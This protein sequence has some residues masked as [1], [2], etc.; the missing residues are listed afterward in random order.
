MET[1]KYQEIKNDIIKRIVNFELTGGDKVPSEAELQKM[2]SVSATTVVKALNELVSEG[3][4]YRVQGKGTFVT[5]DPLGTPMYY[6]DNGYK[7]RHPKESRE[8]L[9]VRKNRGEEVQSVFSN[10]VEVTKI[11]RLR[12]DKNK[13]FAYSIF[14]MDSYYLEGASHHDLQSI[15]EYIKRT[16]GVDLYKASFEEHFQIVL[17]TP[18]YVAQKMHILPSVPTVLAT[19]KTYSPSNEVIE[20]AKTYLDYG[21]FDITISKTK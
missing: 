5:R 11:E 4:V 20:Y 15:Y 14:Y 18:E 13:V 12:L 7:Y 10:N 19:Q 2:Y 1:A 6:Y 8:V 21:T 3:F 17:P 16:K 9:S